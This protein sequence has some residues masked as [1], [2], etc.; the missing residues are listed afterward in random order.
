MKQLLACVALL[1][2]IGFASFLYRNTVERPGTQASDVVCT[3][4]A[5]I[6]PD[7]TSVERGG[8]S[9]AFSACPYPNVELLESTIA[10]ALPEGYEP[11]ER[12][13]TA[14]AAYA[15]PDN[16][17]I[18]IY[19]Y[20]IP[21]G[22]T[23]D[24]IILANTRYQPADEGASDFSRFDQASLRGK[25]FQSTVI[26]RFEGMVMSSYFLVR[27]T[28]VLRFDLVEHGVSGW[29]EPEFDVNSLPEHQAFRSMLS[30]LQTAP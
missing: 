24:D 15:K 20:P 4:E 14:I 28:D 1:A 23:G 21:E 27:D 17:L 12:T 11:D 9:C 19:R 2:V 26:E 30:T 29:M 7:G 3:L 5:K 8:P 6:C 22:E 16:H 10:F 25:T 13:D 18:R